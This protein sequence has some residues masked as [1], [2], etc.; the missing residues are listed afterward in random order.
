M[1]F[2]DLLRDAAN[3]VHAAGDLDRLV[4]E[5][6]DDLWEQDEIRQVKASIDRLYE[7]LEHL[8]V[9]V[10]TRSARGPPRRRR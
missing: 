7:L 9:H 6:D 10:M 4:D 2:G 5:L 3:T 8:S 1:A